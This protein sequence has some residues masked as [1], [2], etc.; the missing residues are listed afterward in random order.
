MYLKIEK[1]PLVCIYKLTIYGSKN[2]SMKINA[3]LY[4]KIFKINRVFT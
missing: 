3:A 1:I 2:E 4:H